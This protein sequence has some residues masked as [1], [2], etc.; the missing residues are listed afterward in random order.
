MPIDSDANR[1]RD[2]ESLDRSCSVLKQD[3]RGDQRSDIRIENGPGRLAEAR[4]DRG[5]NGPTGTQLF[6]NA[7]EDDD[8]RI[9]CHADRQD[10]S[11]NSGQRER[12]LE[13]RHQADQKHEIRK[14]RNAREDPREPVVGHR[15][16]QHQHQPD[17]TSER[18]ALDRILSEAG[19]NRAFFFD[20]DRYGERACA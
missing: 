1:Q 14:Q 4:V 12:R 15:E 19:P 3:D 11:G 13:K 20:D 5:T 17:R 16:D 7:L 8:V 2:C 18:T 9:Y 6:A 10:E